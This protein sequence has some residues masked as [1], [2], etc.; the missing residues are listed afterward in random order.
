MDYT[1]GRMRY[2]I[3]KLNNATRL[4]DE[5]T[6]IMSDKEWDG[7][8][9]QLKE[10][11][12]HL[13]TVYSDSPT[14]KI[15][16]DVKSELSKSKHNH[17]MLSLDKTKDWVEFQ[18][19]FSSIDASKSVV[20]MPKLDGLTCSLRYVDGKLISAET[21]GNGEIGED[22]LHNA[23]TLYN[24]PKEISYS[25]ELIV[26]GEVLC[27]YHNF[28]RF[29]ND[30]KNPRNFA[31]GSIRL[32]NS[33]E[34]AKRGL[35]FVVWN[36]IKGYDKENSF[37]RRLEDVASIGFTVVP[38][39]S[40]IDLDAPE[41]LK[42]RAEEAGY[43]IDGLVGRF[44]DLTFGEL[45]GATG[46]HPR[47]AYAFKF[48]DELY[49]TELLDIEWS[50]G[51]TG[52]FT[53]VAIFKPI[54]IDG[55]VVERASLHNLS[56]MEELNGGFERKGDLVYVFKANG[57]IPQIAKWVHTGDY[58]ESRSI[59]LPTECP[60][61]GKQLYV[62][63]SDSGTLNVMCTNPKCD[64]KLI[65]QLDH[66]LGKKALDIKGISESTLEK[67]VDWGWITNKRDVFALKDHRAEWIKKPGF[68]VASVDKI[69]N[70]IVAGSTTTLDKFI[71]AIGIPEIGET[72]SK[73]IAKNVS[74]YEDFRNK[75]NTK[76]DFTKINTFGE[77]MCYNILKFDYSEADEL[78][79]ILTITNPTEDEIETSENITGK[80]F[81]ITGS[82]NHYKNR[83]EL[84]SQ[85]EKMGGKVIGSVS[86]NTD[87]LICNDKTSGTGKVKDAAALNIPVITETEFVSM[88]GF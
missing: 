20:L 52:Q 43:P 40:T 79:Q 30:Y 46:H 33:E 68:G 19:Y 53:P 25:G 13:H 28:E 72:A 85:I 62:K 38:W 7:L 14:H 22:I 24:V 2:L 76:W 27:T 17:E 75:V 23:M 86:K 45:L 69:L 82:L 49:E 18:K 12:E 44:D 15:I 6:P 74:N 51:R 58:D 77:V 88:I 71:C 26:D 83:A 63:E 65:N 11:E 21:R 8:Y 60:I 84:K 4:Y 67:L 48:Y 16:Y 3:D 42:K 87:Y 80:K 39:T 78:A 54:E 35:M 1:F 34:C 47:S 36:V 37:M 50:L 31:A 59:R 55:S 70:A 41:F 9:F 81:V 32:L 73:L 64:G 29:K 5:G 10:Y 56:I 61:C 57:I 66:M